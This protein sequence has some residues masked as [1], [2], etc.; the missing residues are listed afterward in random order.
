MLNK[1]AL[2]AVFILC[3]LIHAAEPVAPESSVDASIQQLSNPD[4]DVRQKAA[5][6]LMKAGEPARAAML[7]AARADGADAETRA[8]INGIIKSLDAIAAKGERV[9]NEKAYATAYRPNQARFKEKLKDKWVVIAG[10]KL[11]AGADAEPLAFS[12]IEE[13]DAAAI[14]S[15]PNARQRFIFKV[16]DEGDQ[17]CPLG[18]CEKRFVVGNTFFAEV[19]PR[20]V[21]FGNG[22]KFKGVGGSDKWLTVGVEVPGDERSFIRPA[23]KAPLGATELEGTF[24]AST[25]FGGKAVMPA[26]FAAKLQLELWEI[27]GDAIITGEGDNGGVCRRAYAKIKIQQAD[28]TW[29]M[30]VYV[31]KDDEKK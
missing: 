31:W 24:C 22:L 27:P 3:G 15:A 7:K 16:G 23:L 21:V 11:L 14:K 9:E 1:C 5:D 6:Q 20:G 13:A 30:P 17:D 25:G 4:F 12:T 18:G 29:M 19:A 10:G 26:D 28:E 8:R 2:I